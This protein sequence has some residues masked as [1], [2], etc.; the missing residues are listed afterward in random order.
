MNMDEQL[1]LMNVRKASA[2]LWV[3]QLQYRDVK[4]RKVII[5]PSRAASTN[6]PTRRPKTNRAK[7][8]PNVQRRV[9]REVHGD[10]TVW[11]VTHQHYVVSNRAG[12]KEGVNISDGYHYTSRPTTDN[13]ASRRPQPAAKYT[14]PQDLTNDGYVV[15]RSLGHPP[16]RSA[17]MSEGSAG[18]SYMSNDN[19]VVYSNNG[20]T[21]NTSRNTSGYVAPPS[22][23]FQAN[24]WLSGHSARISYM[25]DN[26][27]VVQ[28]G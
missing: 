11:N 6:P 16:I 28:L 14:S 10:G 19:F 15:Y 8:T 5:R 7:T 26:V 9:T 1:L 22:D 27:S 13:S 18:S 4:T 12:N 3:R 17:S 23:R 21:A 2:P 24:S 20:S 25:D